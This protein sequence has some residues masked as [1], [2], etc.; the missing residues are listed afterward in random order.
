MGLL[1]KAENQ[2]AY[3]KVGILGFAGSG[4]TFTATNIALGLCD[5]TKNKK[6]AF[7]DT[8][9]GSD[10]MIKRF[11]KSGIDLFTHKARAFIDL[12]DVTKECEKEG[13]CV[14]IIDSISHVWR[15][16]M[17]SYLVKINKGRSYKKFK[18]LKSLQFQ[19]WGPIKNEWGKFTDLYLN[20]KVHIIMCGR[21]GW[22]YDMTVDEDG[23]KELIKTGTKMKTENEMGYEPSLLLEMERAV[24]DKAKK[25]YT[26]RCTVIKDRSDSL[27]GQQFDMPTFKD[28]LPAVQFLNIGGE[29]VGVDTSRTSEEMFNS[30]GTSITEYQKQID[31]L[32]EQIQET[33]ILGGLDGRKQDVQKKRIEVLIKIFGTSSKTAIE[34]FEPVDLEE[35]LYRLKIELGLSDAPKPI[36]EDEF[37]PV[38]TQQA[39]E[40]F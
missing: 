33:L 11:K 19:H 36:N 14:L 5:L 1:K 25:T 4:K 26:N 10:Y 21:A 15:D 17:D 20:S 37:D 9:T 30:P 32:L 24:L 28:F 13:I 6:A 31:I 8:E 23:N 35:G 12:C 16:L 22:E 27:Q 2:T 39:K 7:F 40:N 29:H 34:N 18:P 38:A 3:L